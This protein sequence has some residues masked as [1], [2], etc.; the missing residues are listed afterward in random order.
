MSTDK[1]AVRQR[2]K[3][4]NRLK[5]EHSERYKLLVHRTLS[6]IYAQ[7]LEPKTKRVIVGFSTRNLTKEKG[8]KTELAKKV[9]LEIAALAQKHNV[10]EVVFDKNG[11]RYHG[12]VKAVAEGAREGGLIF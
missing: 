5:T 11:T 2:R 8:T 9:G 1:E 4:R 6:H 12:R 3:L 7:L 10:K